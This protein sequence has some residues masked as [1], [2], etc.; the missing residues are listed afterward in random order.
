MKSNQRGAAWPYLFILIGLFAL[1]IS[2]PRAWNRVRYSGEPLADLLDH[3]GA[4]VDRVSPQSTDELTIERIPPVTKEVPRQ[5]VLP[6]PAAA[7]AAP[8]AAVNLP[9]E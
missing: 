1:S 2:A 6:S 8:S 9:A 4:K 5:Q 7:P 3:R